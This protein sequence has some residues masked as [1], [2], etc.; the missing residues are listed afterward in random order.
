[1]IGLT[2][3]LIDILDGRGPARASDAAKR[4]HEFFDLSL[5]RNPSN[6]RIECAKGCGFCCHLRV[7]AMALTSDTYSHVTPGYRRT[8]ADALT[9]YL[10]DQ[11]QHA[12]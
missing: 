12:G 2:R 6:H 4:A 1:M 7:S 10:A 11:P 9:T 5:R 8:A 3:I